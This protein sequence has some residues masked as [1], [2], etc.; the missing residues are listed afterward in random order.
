MM[1][2]LIT[3]SEGET[4][5]LGARL[6]KENE[7]YHGEKAIIFALEGE[8][9]TGKT[10]LAK[11]LAK[12]MGVRD[13]VISP[14]FTLEAE[15]DLGK[16]IHIDA[17]RME[18]LQEFLE[19]G[20]NKRLQEKRVMVIEWADKI[21]EVLEKAVGEARVVWVRLSYGVGENE[22]VIEIKEK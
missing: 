4:R 12:A 3:K 15:Y 1:K 9:G 8:L 22:R 6:W 13:D 16:L 11:G 20:F 5:E 21:K 17:W 2:K 18:D 10:Q 19:M 14:T 7:K